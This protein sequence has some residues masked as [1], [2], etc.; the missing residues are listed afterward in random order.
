MK[1]AYKHKHRRGLSTTIG[2]ALSIAAFLA[3]AG[4]ASAHHHHGGSSDPAGTISSYD[5]DTGV[6]T[7]DLAKGG[8]ISGTVSDDTS[9]EV[10]GGC[11]GK[12]GESESR[13][14]RTAKAHATR[15]HFGGDNGWGHH[16]GHHHGHSGSTD[17]LVPGAVVDDAVLVLV[18]GDAVFAKIELESPQSSSAS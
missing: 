15:H 4:T 6:L 12:G 13:A 7:I 14:R 9:I 18:D 2:L 17:D 3:L 8:S 1:Q 16:H 10:G 11:K 5:P